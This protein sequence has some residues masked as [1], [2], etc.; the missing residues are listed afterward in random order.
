MAPA[1]RSTLAEQE[2]IIRWDRESPEVSIWSASPVTWRK[3]ERLGIAAVRQTTFQGGGC[4]GK[5]YRVPVSSLRWGLKRPRK[6]GAA[7]RGFARRV[8]D[9]LKMG[10]PDSS[11]ARPAVSGHA[12]VGP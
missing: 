11:D 3:L 7:P 9:A 8:Q 4:S 1:Y 12:A 6:A 10:S 5:F 2:T